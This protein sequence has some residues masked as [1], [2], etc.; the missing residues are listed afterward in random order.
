M[1]PAILGL[2]VCL[3]VGT[4][5]YGQQ[6]TTDN[7]IDPEKPGLEAID[8]E[9]KK[10]GDEPLLSLGSEFLYDSNSFGFNKDLTKGL[11]RGDV[12]LIG[13]ASIITADL[14]EFD[15]KEQELIATGNV[16]LLSANQV[17]SGRRLRLAY[18]KGEFEVFDAI[19]VAN[20]KVKSQQV[21][22]D[23]LGLTPEESVFAAAKAERLKEIQTQKEDLRRSVIEEGI[24]SLSKDKVEQ[25]AL[26]LEQQILA[27]AIKN[28]LLSEQDD[29]RRRRYL[30]R[31]RYW[32]EAR[33]EAGIT[34]LEKTYYLRLTGSR[35]E[36]VNEY[37]YFAYDATWTS[38]NCDEDEE[39]A[40]SFRSDRIKAQEE[41]YIDFSHPVLAIKGIP[42]LYIPFLR[43]PFKGQRQS[44]FLMPGIQTGDRRNG[45]VYTQPIYFAFAENYDATFTFDLLQN[46]GTRFGVETR[47]EATQSSGFTLKLETIRDRSWLQQ[48]AN[49]DII[50]D[51]NLEN[52]RY[53]TSLRNPPLE[54]LD[55]IAECNA[56]ITEYL[57]SPGNTWRGKQEWQGRY[58]FTPRLTAVTNGTVV[59]DHRYIEDLFLPEDFAAAFATRAQANAYSTAKAAVSYNQTDYF[60]GMH[61]AYG[62]AVLSTSQYSG[63]QMAANARYL[64]RY[65]NL[66]PKLLLNVPLYAS[67]EARHIAIED[68]KSD[69]ILRN[70]DQTSIIGRGAWQQVKASLISPI[71]REGIMRVDA[72]SSVEAR[73]IEHNDLEE[74]QSSIN[75]W[76][77]GLT[78][79]LPI[80]GMA[81]LPRFVQSLLSDEDEDEGEKIIHHI[82]D[83]SLSYSARPSVARRGPY[84]TLNEAGQPR[85]YFAT[86]RD[87]VVNP[88]DGRDVTIED[89]MLRHQ[90]V[91]FGTSQRWRFFN[92]QWQIEP[93]A[94]P[95]SDGGNEEVTETLRERARRELVSSL[96]QPLGAERE[97]FSLSSAN[98]PSWYFNRYRLVDSNSIQPITFSATMT[99]DFEQEKR[100]EQVKE[101]NRELEGLAAAA[102]TEEQAQ[103]LRSQVVSY[104][105][106]PES[107]AGPFFNLGLNWNDFA[108]STFVNYNIY[109]RTS[110]EI[111]FGLTLPRVVD[112][113]FSANYILE[114]RPLTLGDVNG[115]FTFRNTRIA[116]VGISTGLIPYIS[117]GINLIR[118]E[119]EDEPQ[120]YGTS[121]N[122]AYVDRSGCW[123]LRFVREKDLNRDEADAN[124]ILQLSVI[125]F[126]SNRAGDI[127][128]ALEREIPR[129]TA[130]GG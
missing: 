14:I 17:F 59:S 63:L 83:W 45:F 66:N 78:L 82:M 70:Q 41:G 21:V 128:P 117:T 87:F 27:K 30:K 18:E 99:F 121:I 57:R 23:I 69:S 10:K 124:Y 79:N 103:E 114:K 33:S 38:C 9:E 74:K 94:V 72:F 34:A 56:E 29:E 58:F 116:S 73:F 24:D 52:N 93:G 126:G 42:V 120:Q 80:D 105:N 97:L 35:I 39:P 108:L 51:Y 25:Y 95:D 40:W 54:N 90:R 55:E 75:S 84:G 37:D 100:R 123:G 49:L 92:R 106:L 50:R 1:I 68:R 112:T 104:T 107:W 109:Q 60:L 36:K 13:N 46:R 12:V 89:S 77:T 110:N 5:L 43:V 61:S 86:D 67:A 26:F 102:T 113:A 22:S 62:D 119:I 76:R 15:R 111:R 115:S 129:F 125:F 53:C 20:D 32:Q 28:P 91:T 16:L 6:E 64:S 47:Y 19:M 7:F 96:D 85:V 81:P 71:V 122:L 8:E 4:K 11:F 127:S 101:R 44:G 65:Y 118:K 3:V 130:F 48:N 2:L 98:Q 88:Q 31:R